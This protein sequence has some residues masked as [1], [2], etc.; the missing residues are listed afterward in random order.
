[1]AAIFFSP[2][3]VNGL[4]LT[5]V[6][7]VPR[8]DTVNCKC[9]HYSA[10]IRWVGLAHRKAWIN[11][12]WPADAI[13]WHKSGSKLVQVMAC[14]L[15]APSHYLNQCWEIISEVLMQS[16]EGNITENDQDIYQWYEFENYEFKITVASPNDL[17]Y[18]I[19]SLVLVT[20][21]QSF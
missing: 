4:T 7:G 10:N 15:T 5:S 18:L 1:M 17:S 6:G 11:S 16:H 3:C 2:Q 13:L 20:S 21:L 8:S 12:P 19:K 14:C 9:Q